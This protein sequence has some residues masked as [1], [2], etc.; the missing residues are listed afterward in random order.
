MKK[1]TA[2]FLALILIVSVFAGCASA[3]SAPAPAAST[4]PAAPA[5]PTAPG[6]PAGSGNIIV[7]LWDYSN[8][9]YYKTMFEAFES[10]F[11]YTIEV[12]ES[13]SADYIDHVLIMLAGG[14]AVDALFLKGVP[15][16]STLIGLNHLL[17]VNDYIAASNVDQGAY[18]NL[19]DHLQRDG[20]VYGVPFRKD[21]FMLYYNKDLFD[22]AGVA[23]PTDGMN[24]QQ[25]RTLAAQMT[26]GT[27]ND[28]VYGAHVHT[29]VSQLF[30]MPRRVGEFDPLRE[31]I[32]PALTPYYETILAMQNEDESIM[33][34]AALRAGSV[35]YSGVFY[36]QQ[37]AMVNMGTWFTNML[38][39]N[40][41]TDF[42]WGAVSMPS[43][44]GIG[45]TGGVGGVT[46]ICINRN[47]ANPQGAWDFI[48]YVTGQEGATILAG[49][50]I[51]PGFTNAAVVAEILKLP[52]V[53]AD[54]ANYLTVPIIIDTE[55]HPST[56]EVEN[57]IGDQHLL[58]MTGSISIAEGLAE[59]QQDINRILS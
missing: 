4:A 37:V 44:T 42:A 1:R 18:S 2:M 20:D 55:M 35:H 36:N 49:T 28:K 30:I 40:V 46:P 17:P 12:L 24:L 13:P 26:S 41:G 7:S 31:D 6:T 16:L 48:N 8:T 15:E 3:P 29:W 51:L 58:I 5:A 11:P 59:A 53:P 38:V 22:A 34:F 14:A 50:G 45:N 33:D 32:V 52:G 27:G 9:E 47:A 43:A 10:E 54:M 23:Y 19:F 21:N 56:R 39:E 25:F 57:A